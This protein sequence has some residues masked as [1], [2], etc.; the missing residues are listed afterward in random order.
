M[1]LCDS[2]LKIDDVVYIFFV[3]FYWKFD[4]VFGY[5]VVIVVIDNV[6]KGVVL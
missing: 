6:M 5:V 3:D 4:E 1:R 2:F